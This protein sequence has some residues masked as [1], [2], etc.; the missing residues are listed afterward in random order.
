LDLPNYQFRNSKCEHFEKWAM[1]DDV[2]SISVIMVSGYFGNPASTFGHT[3]LKFNSQNSE[4]YL[5]LTFN[6]GA[7]VPENEPVIRYIYRGIFGGYESGFS[8]GYYYQQDMVYTRTEFRD[9]WDYE[10]NFTD[11]ERHLI[12][13]HLWEVSGKKFDYYFLTKNCALRIAEIL[14]ITD[15]TNHLT[16]RS[17]LWYAPIELFNRINDLDLAKSSGYINKI[18]FV[19]SSERFLNSRLMSLDN[20]EINAFNDAVSSGVIKVPL[21]KRREINVLNS[22]IEYYEFKDISLSDPDNVIYK[23]LKRKVLQRRLQLPPAEENYIAINPLPSPRKT[24]PPMMLALG[25]NY[26]EQNANNNSAIIRFSPFFYDSVSLNSLQGGELVVFD[27]TIKINGNH[28]ASINNIDI[29][30]LRKSPNNS[31][32]TTK[33]KEL[34]WSAKLSIE[35]NINDD[36]TPLLSLGLF[37]DLPVK[38]TN[39][40]YGADALLK[41]D[42]QTTLYAEPYIS[43]RYSHERYK[44]LAKFT[45]KYNFMNHRTTGIAELKLGYFFNPNRALRLEIGNRDKKQLTVL[46][47]FFM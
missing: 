32:V 6:Y 5:D 22:L 37:D 18:K 26:A 17:K 13:S 30:R 39:F 38:N 33:G 1:L 14:Q 29:I 27:A 2:Q 8:D 4:R 46:Y 42:T 3:L 45:N 24:S 20:I 43:L 23:S 40:S 47:Q 7:L 35:T 9:M 12:I 25:L 41:H 19:P 15:D 11:F 10:L 36:L 34:G 44:I 31:F 21:D 28:G 16:T